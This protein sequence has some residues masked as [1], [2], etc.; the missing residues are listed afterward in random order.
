VQ[1]RHLEQKGVSQQRMIDAQQLDL[2]SQQQEFMARIRDLEMKL[3][4]MEHALVAAPAGKSLAQ[5]PSQRVRATEQATVH[6]SAIATHHHVYPAGNTSQ[7]GGVN[8]CHPHQRVQGAAGKQ[9]HHA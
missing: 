8:S 2:R 6:V 4:N 9:Q 1:V 3:T 5:S 7:G